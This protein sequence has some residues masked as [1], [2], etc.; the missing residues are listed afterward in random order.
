MTTDNVKPLR[1]VLMIFLI[2][3]IAFC[4]VA[5]YFYLS[6]RSFIQTATKTEGRVVNLQM[7]RKGGKAPIIEYYD[8]EGKNHFYYHNVYSQPSSYALGEKTEIY[9]N[10]ADPEDTRMGGFQFVVFIFGFLGVVFSFVS[11]ICIKVL[12]NRGAIQQKTTL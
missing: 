1:W 10:P 8:K 12:W 11:I 5:A 3:G 6:Y 2:L 4:S 9:Y 7:N